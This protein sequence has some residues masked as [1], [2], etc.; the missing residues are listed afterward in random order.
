[1]IKEQ[2]EEENTS[3]IKS[4]KNRLSTYI[5]DFKPLDTGWFLNVKLTALIHCIF[6]KYQ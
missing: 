2:R 5:K 3:T 4:L 1:M 6:Y